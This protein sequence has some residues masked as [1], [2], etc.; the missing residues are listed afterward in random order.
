MENITEISVRKL[1]Y[2]KWI[3]RLEVPNIYWIKFE[4]IEGSLAKIEEIIA[5]NIKRLKS[6]K[7]E[8]NEFRPFNE[9]VYTEN[10]I[11]EITNRISFVVDQYKEYGDKELVLEKEIL[12]QLA[13]GT[14]SILEEGL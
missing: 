6:L 14:V 12:E 8:N 9:W 4:P 10:T 13:N 1:M 3:F 2:D 11:K 7:L 5:R